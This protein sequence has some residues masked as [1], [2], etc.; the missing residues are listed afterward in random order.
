[1]DKVEIL[2]EIIGNA[3]GMSLRAMY[4][5]LNDYRELAREFGLD[6]VE[7]NKGI[8]KWKKIIRAKLKKDEIERECRRVVRN[9]GDSYVM[10]IRLG[11]FDSLSDADDYFVWNEY[12]HYIPSPYDCTGQAFTNW[13][14]VFERNGEYWAYHSV[15]FDV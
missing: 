4:K 6:D 12:R 1:M 11:E 15:S 14:K 9:F 3:R 10:L 5:T 7:Q 8:V 2:D 13:Y